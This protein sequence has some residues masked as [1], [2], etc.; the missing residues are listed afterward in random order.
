MIVGLIAEARMADPRT[1]D[2]YRAIAAGALKEAERA[3]A[4]LN[5]RRPRLPLDGLLIAL[6]PPVLT[7]LQTHKSK[8]QIPL[9]LA[10]LVIGL[11][12][13]FLKFRRELADPKA[14]R[15]KAAL[16]NLVEGLQPIPT[17]RVLTAWHRTIVD[18]AQGTLEILARA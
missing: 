2:D 17:A 12:V 15:S 18:R 9:T 13:A 1:D 4:E 11:M 10:A 6:A 3:L 7:A 8:E 5:D 14:E 16:R